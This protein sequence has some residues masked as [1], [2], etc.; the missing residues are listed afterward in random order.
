MLPRQNT[1]CSYHYIETHLFNACVLIWTVNKK[2]CWNI[3]LK[4]VK[5]LFCKLILLLYFILQAKY[6]YPI[7]MQFTTNLYSFCFDHKII[8]FKMSIWSSQSV[9]SGE[10]GNHPITP[11]KEITCPGNISLTI[12]RCDALWFYLFRSISSPRCSNIALKT[13]EALKEMIA[14]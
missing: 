14:W 6:L 2:M 5:Y 9:A 7:T 11:R 3:Y 12:A 8:I 4:K 10:R 13:E 1:W